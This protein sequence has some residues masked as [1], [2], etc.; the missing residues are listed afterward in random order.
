MRGKNRDLS[1]EWGQFERL[2]DMI[3]MGEHLQEGGAWITKEYKRL[4]KLLLPKETAEFNKRTRELKNK[5]INDIVAKGVERDRC[6]KCRGELE[7]VRKGSYIVK[8]KECGA[9]FKYK[10]TRGRKK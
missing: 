4:Q 6:S 7:Q 3:G 9:R 8:C 10:V 1:F 5:Q 2:G